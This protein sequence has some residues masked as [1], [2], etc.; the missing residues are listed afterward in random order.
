MNARLLIMLLFLLL[1][2]C[3]E[4]FARGFRSPA[5]IGQPQMLAQGQSRPAQIRPVSP[6]RVRQAVDSIAQA[7][8]G[9]GLPAL[10]DN[11]FASRDRLLDTMLTVVPRDARLR[12]TAVQSVATLDQIIETLPGQP[13]K[14]ISTVSVL[15][16]TQIE[17]NDPV[18]GFQR[19]RGL[20]EFLLR[21]TETD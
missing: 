20:N 6:E 3:G 17:F 11:S 18:T 4:T 19:L 14:R 9:E 16:E 21:F 12:V 7:W 13:P 2:P 1:Q 15:V 10:L 5:Q 8:N